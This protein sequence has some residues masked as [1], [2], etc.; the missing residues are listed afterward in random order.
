MKLKRVIIKNYRNLKDIA[1]NLPDSNIIAFIG[2][3]G[4]GKSNILENIAHTFSVAK[5]FN[6]RN[7]V[8]LATR[9]CEAEPIFDSFHSIDKTYFGVTKHNKFVYNKNPF[10]PTIDEINAP[11]EKIVG[12]SVT[13][14]PTV[15]ALHS[16]PA[17]DY[18]RYDITGLSAVLNYG[19]HCG[20]VNEDDFFQFAKKC[21]QN[22]I[23]IW[24]ASFKDKDS[25][26]YE[27]LSKILSL[28]NINRLYNISPEA[29]Y[30]KLILAYSL[31]EKLVNEN[32]FFENL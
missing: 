9:L 32:L 13:L 17:F 8:Y 4:S 21:S 31:N 25:P 1:I 16:S 15:S 24:L 19:Y 14:K 7:A 6:N 5:D 23:D 29:A 18:Y 3:N 22:N 11:R 26:I 12:D 2:N 28:P 30:A 20:T 27:T 10:N